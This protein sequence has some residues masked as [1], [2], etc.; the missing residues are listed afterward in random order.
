M[1]MAQFRTLAARLIRSTSL[2]EL[3]KHLE[4]EVQGVARFGFVP[5]QW[6]SV[7]SRLDRFHGHRG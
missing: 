5:W 4:F 1:A 7:N 6:L 2:S 3:T